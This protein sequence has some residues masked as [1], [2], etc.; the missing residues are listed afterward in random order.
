MSDEWT[1]VRNGG[2]EP[3]LPTGQIAGRSSTRTRNI[4]RSLFR[5][6]RRNFRS[7]FFFGRGRHPRFSRLALQ[8]QR[9]APVFSWKPIRNRHREYKNKSETENRESAVRPSFTRISCEDVPRPHSEFT[10]RIPRRRYVYAGT[11]SNPCNIIAPRSHEERG[12]GERG[13]GLKKNRHQVNRR[14]RR[15][16]KFLINPIN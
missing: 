5:L 13:D 12:M 8:T 9:F 14:E 15:G 3:R 6:S 2:D 16:A 10:W 7:P 4:D 11:S 1:E